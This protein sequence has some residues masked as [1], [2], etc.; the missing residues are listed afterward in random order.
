[1]TL[2]EVLY[3]LIDFHNV[4]QESDRYDSNLAL[5][6]AL[7]KIIVSYYLLNEYVETQTFSSKDIAKSYTIPM[8][9]FGHRLFW[10]KY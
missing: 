4:S 9:A 5:V 8:L 10:T 2:K 6:S 7:M 1:M 3:F